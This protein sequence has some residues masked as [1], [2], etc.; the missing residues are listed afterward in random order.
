MLHAIALLA[1]IHSLTSFIFGCGITAELDQE[2]EGHTYD[3]DE[4]SSE[5]DS[6]KELSQNG[7]NSIPL[8]QVNV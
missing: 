2:T 8:L 5:T 1:H 4:I 6:D 3:T 7:F